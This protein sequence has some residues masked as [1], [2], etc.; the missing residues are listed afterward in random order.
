MDDAMLRNVQLIQ[1]EIAKEVKRICEQNNISYFM[2]GGT[3]LGAVRHKGFIP[4]DDDLDF[5]FTRD[6]YENLLLQPRKICRPNFSCKLGILIENMDM[7]LQKYERREQFIK[8]E[9]LRTAMQTVGFLLIYF[10]TII[11]QMTKIKE[12]NLLQN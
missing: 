9:L 8:R 5:G 12:E 2:D 10:L 6:N 7:L 3:L 11:Y 4:W 1:L